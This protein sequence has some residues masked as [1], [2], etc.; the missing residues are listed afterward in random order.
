M[1][2]NVSSAIAVAPQRSADLARAKRHSGRPAPRA[3]QPVRTQQLTLLRA[4]RN[5]RD[6]QALL[7]KSSVTLV[8]QLGGEW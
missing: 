6:T 8:Q 1:L 5:L 3:A 4:G 2:R 7:A